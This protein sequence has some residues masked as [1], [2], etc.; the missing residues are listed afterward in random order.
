MDR[1]PHAHPTLLSVL[2]DT[3]EPPRVVVLRGRSNDLAPFQAILKSK[4]RLGEL[5][6]PIPAEAE[7]LPPVL[8]SKAATGKATAYVCRGMVCGP[9]LTQPDHLLL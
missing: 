5:V 4:P 2:A 9:P 7:D 1:H 3:L 8:A 6:F